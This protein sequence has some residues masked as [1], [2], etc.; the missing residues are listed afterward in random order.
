MGLLNCQL[1]GVVIGFTIGM[2]Q[3]DSKKLYMDLDFIHFARGMSSYFYGLS[4]FKDLAEA[5]HRRDTTLTLV[6]L[7]FR[8]DR[9]NNIHIE[10]K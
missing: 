10:S 1:Q 3:E 6:Q 5:L 9:C 8:T 2:V 4:S 7:L